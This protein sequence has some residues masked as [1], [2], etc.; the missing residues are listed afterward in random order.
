MLGATMTDISLFDYDLP[1]SF[2]AQMPTEPRDASKLLVMDRATG[3]T[4]HHVFRDI[5]D[6]LRTDDVLVF[7]VSKVFKAR[8]V[9]DGVEMFVLRMRDE[10]ADV[11]LRPG[12]KFAVGSVVFGEF[13]VQKKRD[14][15]IVTVATGM[16]VDEMLAYC[17]A[18]G[19]VP[20]PPYVTT[21]IEEA[22]YQT[23][24]ARDTGSVAAPTAGLHFTP[25]LL[26]RIR[27]KGVTI[28]EVTLH[29][30]IGK[31]RPVQSATLEEH[32]MHS[33]WVHIDDAV[34]ER[35][36]IAKKSGRRIIAVGTTTV[37]VLEGVTKTCGELRGYSGE[38]NIFITPGFGFQIIDGLITN[39]H[40][41]K[42]TLLVLV[43]T[44]AG[45]DNTLTSYELAKREHY[46]FF[47]FG[48][49]MFIA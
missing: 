45:R 2:I 43:S 37:R 28:E 44:F 11:L 46:R 30:G 5:V 38:I 23:V 49:A 29:V 35:I 34:A 1:T 19:T 31:F 47:S 15:G 48:D 7:N 14:D 13:E 10:E 22:R 12:K 16:T 25:E 36:T 20:T 33:E 9:E 4:S 41:P 18:H 21:N 6:L 17:D 24:Y 8:I 32:V 26:D 3:E 27:A 42:S 40:L 39:F